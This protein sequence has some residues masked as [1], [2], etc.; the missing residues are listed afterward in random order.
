MFEFLRKLIIMAL[1]WLEL[2]RFLSQNQSIYIILNG[3]GVRCDVDIFKLTAS[4]QYINR[5][6]YAWVYRS[7][8]VAT[9]QRSGLSDKPV[10][11]Q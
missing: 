10:L 6:V 3:I 8:G 11:H 2:T 7:P 5:Q 1:I 4:A 9:P